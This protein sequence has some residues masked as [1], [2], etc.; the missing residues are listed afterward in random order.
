MKSS[1]GLINVFALILLFTTISL[2]AMEFT[3]N[4]L[5]I[6]TTESYSAERANFDL[7][8]LDAFLSSKQSSSIKSIT[9]K[10]ENQFFVVK[11]QSSFSRE[12]ILNLDFPGVEYIQ[13]N[14]LNSFYDLPDDP[15]YQ[16]QERML[17]LARIPA[18]WNVSLGNSEIVVALVD[19]GIHFD[20]PDLQN[21]IFINEGEIPDDGIDND[22]NGYI[23]D[24]RGWD[25]VDAP[26]L[27]DLAEGDF[28]DQDNDATDEISHGT[29]LAGIIAA[30]TD[31][32]EGVSGINWFSSLLPIRAG[33]NTG[34][35]GYL[36]DDDAAAAIIY[37]AD[38]GA[39]VI[40]LSWG[41]TS[42]SPIIADACSY[43]YNKGSILVAS[44]GNT[45]QIGIMYPARLST[46]IAVGAVDKF[47]NI[48]SFSSYG[49]ELDIMAPGVN[50]L[51]T[52]SPD[53][54]DLYKLQSGTSMAAPFVSGS[55]AQL[56]NMEP[57][58]DFHEVKARLQF[59]AKDLGDPG[60]DNFYGS[61]LLDTY[62]LLTSSDQPVIEVSYPA[63]FSGI[64]SN[65]DLMG[66]VTS[67]DFSKYCVMYTVKENPVGLDWKDIT[68]QENT[69]VYYYAE[70]YDDIIAH[71][72]IDGL[73]DDEYLIKIEVITSKNEHF[74]NVFH[75]NIDQTA[76]ELNEQTVAVMLRYDE[77]R[78]AY[79][80]Q[81]L[82]DD[83][84]DLET[85][86]YEGGEES[87]TFSQIPS[88]LQITRLPVMAPAVVDV[89]LTAIN[90]S[91]METD[92]T[93]PAVFQL[94]DDYV[95]VNSYELVTAGNM[96]DSS[97][98][99][100]DFDGNG[101]M[102][103]SGVEKI[104][105]NEFQVGIYEFLNDTPIL[106]NIIP[107]QNVVSVLGMGDTNND[108]RYEVLTW[109]Q[110]SV[111]T[112]YE[113]L[114]D[115]LSGDLYPNQIVWADTAFY[116]A[117]FLDYNGDGDDEIVAIKNY[118]NYDIGVTFRALYLFNRYGMNFEEEFILI[119]PSDTNIKNEFVSIDCGDLDGDI[120]PDLITADKDGDVMIFEI[121]NNEPVL[122]WMY[123][124]PVGDCSYLKICDLNGDGINE[125]LVGGFN[126][127]DQVPEKSFSYFSLFQNSGTNDSYEALGY[128]SFSNLV[129]SNSLTAV[130]IDGNG[131]DELV[132]NVSPNIYVADYINNQLKPVW[133]GKAS[134]ESNNMLGVVP[135][136]EFEV[137]R[138]VTSVWDGDNY[139]AAVLK[140]AEP[141]N[142]PVTPE[143]VEAVPLNSLQVNLSWN[144]N[145]EVDYFTVYQKQ[146][147]IVSNVGN[148]T[149]TDLELNGFAQ[150]DS[151]Y[152]CVTAN[153]DNFLPVE[154]R[155]T[156]W[157]LAV[158]APVP[159]VESIQMVSSNQ[160]KLIFDTE[161]S[162][163]AISREIYKLN[164]D[165][166]YPASV[167]TINANRGVL[168]YFAEPLTE[169][170]DYV[171]NVTGLAGRTGVAVPEQHLSFSYQND[172]K[173]PEIIEALT[174]KMDI[175]NVYFSEPLRLEGSEDFA[176]FMVTPPPLDS[177]NQVVDLDYIQDNSGYY[178][179]MRFE[180]DL[181]YTN[182][183][184]FLLVEN[185][186]D[187]AGNLIDNQGNKCHFSL[188][189]TEGLRNLKNLKVYPNPLNINDLKDG[190]EF[191]IRFSDF[192]L[193]KKGEIK[194]Y[195]LAGNLVFED[196]VGPIA[197]ATQ[198]YR[199]NVRN[200]DNRRVS[201][202]IYFY[203]LR[204]NGDSR[205][206]KIVII[207]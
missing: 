191:S 148:F 78:P 68:T 67:P 159:Q 163:Q 173:G 6:K 99:Y 90:R 126:R 184:Y 61:G 8:E 174:E 207:N 154:S 48:A 70:V 135:A 161:L 59:T 93:L 72:N 130:D 123:R 96:I 105:D 198:A 30:D 91:G 50:I 118:T 172:T 7:P 40:N 152:F 167:N 9:K 52:Y 190:E 180:E 142:G 76:P 10:A 149:E 196:Q 79:Y 201:S 60:Y 115:T 158:T 85:R 58:L 156:L 199:W 107:A 86:C 138:V 169:F 55:I 108:S 44:S 74:S 31:N 133:F 16:E 125:F 128:L 32:G 57:N 63:D 45:Y 100:Y 98:D 182:Q 202:G 22:N 151:V 95:D 129:E 153:N 62:A 200:N 147:G 164:N 186:Y 87:S 120:Y 56:L 185:L 64:N 102:E 15:L 160:V 179:Q 35:S 116:D 106:K 203:Y 97:G 3:P 114:G 189:G 36:Q 80:L 141:F 137:G 110:G 165:Y 39:D 175:V 177:D 69:P 14:Y 94:M 46:T 77:E 205:K 89:S 143:V 206:G 144:Y 119:N 178:V 24:W 124:I 42:Y 188:T 33:F 195:N 132:I 139:Q 27:Y 193:N 111:A 26:E 192:P 171:L 170:S 117:K 75:L 71:L 121:I 104:S 176:N 29:H 17:E 136:S 103:F 183:N 37:A 204:M 1:L 101:K 84:V 109:G 18:A 65:I 145:D 28:L 13:P 112:L 88:N 168:L 47:S 146:N 34:G 131:D 73:P 92:T 166:D 23:D 51:S 19:S 113:V 5:I 197:A 12:E 194:I 21:N 54:A 66:R 11:V 83:V 49:P 127:N 2:S 122:S 134:C 43:A 140:L 38:M 181:K 157:S 53:G 4:E 187:E 20:H 25:F 155:P 162:N 150:G 41:D 82:Y 81:T